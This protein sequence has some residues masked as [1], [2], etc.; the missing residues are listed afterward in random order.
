MSGSGGVTT[1]SD[2][3]GPGTAGGPPVDRPAVLAVDIGGTKL[4]VG[5]VDGHGAVLVEAREA[6]N[7]RDAEELFDRKLAWHHGI[8]ADAARMA[9][10]G[11]KNC[12]REVL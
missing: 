12:L 8:D 4:A 2:P 6:T 1:G 9:I 3:A 11:K 5:I 7:G 10:S